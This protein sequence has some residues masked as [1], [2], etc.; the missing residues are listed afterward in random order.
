MMRDA[1]WSLILFTLLTQLAVGM[2][3]VACA[4]NITYISKAN[5]LTAREI[6][7]KVMLVVIVILIIAVAASFIHLGKPKSAPFAL[8]HFSKSWLSREIVF[9]ILFAVLAGTA[10]L[11]LRILGGTNV[12]AQ[13]F[14][15]VAGVIG[16]ITIISMAKVYMLDTVPAWNNFSTPIQFISASFIL[17]GLGTIMLFLLFGEGFD[18]GGTVGAI[19]RVLLPALLVFGAVNLIA[20][21]VHLHNLP[22]TGIAGLESFKILTEEHVV[23]LILRLILIAV[24]VV[25][26]CVLTFANLKTYT[27]YLFYILCSV[28]LISEIIGRYL[29]YASYSR[30]GV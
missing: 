3:V 5:S 9:L 26:F 28:V 22:G 20:F 24:A 30:V 10:L 7:D 16:I 14:A 23:L 17:G 19:N 21:I 1:E 25:L 27:P 2:F 12:V 15:V 29:F 11:L 13:R 6:V 18:S 8:S 4:A